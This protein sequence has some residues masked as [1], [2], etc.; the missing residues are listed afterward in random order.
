MKKEPMQKSIKMFKAGQPVVLIGETTHD[1]EIFIF[2]SPE[3][4]VETLRVA[5]K[6]PFK[7]NQEFMES[8][9]KALNSH[10]TLHVNFHN[11]ESF[12]ESLIRYGICIP[13]TLN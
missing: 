10:D 7:N 1:R 9:S 2:N 4:F 11:E 8:V 5:E 12:V 13:A 6:V 3:N